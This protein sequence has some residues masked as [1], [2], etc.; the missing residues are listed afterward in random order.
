M[1]T[2]LEGIDVSSAQ[3]EIDWHAVA[4][5][6]ISFAYARCSEGVDWE[7]PRFAHYVAG[8]QAA[9]LPVG[10]YHVIRPRAGAQDGERQAQQY[11]ERMRRVGCT[12]LPMIDCENTPGTRGLP[13]TAWAEAIRGWLHVVDAE[14]GAPALIYTYP[15][16]WDAIAALHADDFAAHPL[17][18][19]HY[20]THA[21]WIPRPW[22][23]SK[24]W[25]YAAGAGVVGHVAGVHGPVDMDR[26]YGSLDEITIGGAGHTPDTDPAPA[27]RAMFNLDDV[28]G[29]AA[30]LARLGYV[31]TA[32]LAAATRAFQ[33][34]HPPLAVD[35]KIGEHTKAAM[36]AALADVGAG[37]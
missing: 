2:T 18:I 30:A 36:R 8:A 21:P 16:F 10:A 24:I 13:G 14:F 20:T 22:K 31:L 33:K 25:Q 3:G 1:T 17:W 26:L 11:L 34:D 32:G 29:Q 19:A 15:G 37:E 5:D 6:G 12:L 23:A 4:A 7:D 35:A 28:H 27:P 9:G